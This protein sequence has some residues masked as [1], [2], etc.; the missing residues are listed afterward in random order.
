LFVFRGLF[1]DDITDNDMD[2]LAKLFITKLLSNDIRLVCLDFDQTII[3]E[4][5]RGRWGSTPGQ[6]AT[7][8][9]M[10]IEDGLKVAITTF[11]S[12]TKLI[13]QFLTEIFGSNYD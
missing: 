12:Q 4:H 7:H 13:Q 5:T 11:S 10:T 6:L 2:N 1:I 3:T 9:P 8:I